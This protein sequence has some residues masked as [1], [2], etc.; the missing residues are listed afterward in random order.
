MEWD[1]PASE[2]GLKTHTSHTVRDKEADNDGIISSP[3]LPFDGSLESP[4]SSV[5]IS[6]NALRPSIL[7]PTVVSGRTQRRR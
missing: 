4:V 5:R 1:P 7:L 3:L 2:I 6:V